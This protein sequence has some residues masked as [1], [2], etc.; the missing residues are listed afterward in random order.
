MFNHYP[1]SDFHELN[2]D[3]ILRKIKEL[4]IKIDEFEALNTITYAGFWDITKQYPKWNIV[5][6]ENIGYIS[7]Q[8]VPAGI[9]IDNSLYWLPIIDYAASAEFKTVIFIGD[10]YMT[11]NDQ[12]LAHSMA[13]RLGLSPSQYIVS[14]LGSTGFARQAGGKR[15]IDLLQ[16]AEG[17]VTPSDV[18]HIIV[19]GGANDTLM[20]DAQTKSYMHSFYEYAKEHF[21]NAKNYVGFVG[22]TSVTTNILPYAS[23]CL[24][25]RQGA[26]AENVI[27]LKN[28]EYVLHNYE[29]LIADQVHPTIDGTNELAYKCAEA[30]ITG[31]CDVHYAFTVTTSD[32][33]SNIYINIDNETTSIYT[34]TKGNNLQENPR[35]S[36]NPGNDVK[37][38]EIIGLPIVGSYDRFPTC[39]AASQ[40]FYNSGADVITMPI[41]YMLYSGE[42][43]I[44]HCGY[45]ALSDV[46]L[47]TLPQFSISFPTLYC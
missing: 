22:A 9:S 30:L 7:L 29:L 21:P 41:A 44:R 19:L 16:D 38:E 33:W 23:R 31:S 25:Y 13:E 42:L 4:G 11:R 39:A 2:L 43:H 10:S 1:Y 27:Y 47:I 5:T 8:P 17:L 40:V 28:V 14:A 34:L 35:I 6:N 37:V 32:Y 36:F 3:W 15:F 12:L 18:S 45:D 26:T 24:T 20:T 46:N